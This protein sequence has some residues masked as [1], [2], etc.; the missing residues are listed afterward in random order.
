MEFEGQVKKLR[1][2]TIGEYNYLVSK[3]AKTYI[4][5]HGL[6]YRII[7]ELVG[8]LECA[9]AEMS[10]RILETY[11]D[12]RIKEFGDIWDLKEPE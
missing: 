9:K 1:I 11:E 6:S 2:D 10:R 7:N 12:D 5:Q 4:Q 8:A 3:I